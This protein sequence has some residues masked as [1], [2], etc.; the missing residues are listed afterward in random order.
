MKLYLVLAITLALPCVSMEQS[1][2]VPPEQIKRA[3]TQENLMRR[4]MVGIYQSG[5]IDTQ[6]IQNHILQSSVNI[7]LGTLLNIKNDEGISLLHA[8]ADKQDYDFMR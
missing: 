5:Q 3:K 2:A 1:G 4:A 7:P 6:S 8:A